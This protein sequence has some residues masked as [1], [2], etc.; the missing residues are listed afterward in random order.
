LAILATFL[1]PLDRVLHLRKRIQRR[2]FLQRGDPSAALLL[3]P[4]FKQAGNLEVKVC[5]PSS[6]AT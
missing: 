5:D 2:Q 1:L 3:P 6:I 4:Y